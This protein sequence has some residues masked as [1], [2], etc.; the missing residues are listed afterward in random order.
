MQ[1][2]RKPPTIEVVIFKNKDESFEELKSYFENDVYLFRK[3]P[4]DGEM[5]VEIRSHEG[6]KRPEPG[7]Y[8]VREENKLLVLNK[9]KFDSIYARVS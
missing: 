9:E 7:D 5:V 2:T 8:V 1:Y 3:S 6:V 4:E